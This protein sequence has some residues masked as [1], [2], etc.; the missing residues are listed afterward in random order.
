MGITPELVESDRSNDGLSVQLVRGSD[1]TILERSDY[2]EPSKTPGKI[3]ARYLAGR[4]V[5]PAQAAIA[6]RRV[7]MR[8]GIL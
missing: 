5:T 8:S 4:I 3:R 2:T 1:T 7:L 6:L